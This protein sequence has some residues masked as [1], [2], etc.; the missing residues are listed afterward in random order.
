MEQLRLGTLLVMALAPGTGEGAAYQQARDLL[1]PDPLPTPTPAKRKPQAT[2]AVRFVSYFFKGDV[3]EPLGIAVV[4]LTVINVRS[5]PGCSYPTINT[6]DGRTPVQVWAEQDGWVLVSE[7][8]GGRP[9][10]GWVAS[11]LVKPQ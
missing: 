5:G 3:P 7:L 1:A 9:V 2:A 11:E 10:A 8:E 4:Q 6:L